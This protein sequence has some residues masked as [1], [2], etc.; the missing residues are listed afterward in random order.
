[1]AIYVPP[2]GDKVAFPFASGTPYVI[3]GG[4]DVAFRFGGT[5]GSLFAVGLDSSIFG[6]AVL[7]NAT[8]E[9]FPSGWASGLV[10]GNLVFTKSLLV[11]GIPPGEFGQALLYNLSQE[12][13]LGAID[14]FASGIPWVSLG[15][16]RLTGLTIADAS[17][18]GTATMSGGV[19][20]VDM[21]GLGV[22]P[23]VPPSPVVWFQVREIFPA[24]FVATLWGLPLMDFQH[25]VFLGGFG[26]EVFGQAEFFRPRFI[27]DMQ[28]LGIRGTVWGDTTLRLAKQFVAPPGWIG[29]GPTSA[30]QFGRT[31]IYNLK[32]IIEQQFDVTPGDGGVFGDFNLVMNRNQTPRPDGLAAGRY[33]TP[34]LR[35]AARIV[36]TPSFID[37]TLWGDNLVAPAIRAI[38]FVGTETTIWG[39]NVGT[40]V[41]NG[42]RVLAPS[43]IDSGTMGKPSRVWSNLQTLR[44]VGADQSA[45]G[46]QMVDFAIRTVSPFS[47]PGPPP[48]GNVD[49]ENWIRFVRVP[50]FAAGGAGVPT[51]E[52]HFTI[53]APRS[54]LPPANAF[55]EGRVRNVTPELPIFGWTATMFGASAIH[56]QFE[57]YAFQSFGGETFG[58]HVVKDRRITV[59][60]NGVGPLPISQLHQVRNVTPDPPSQQIVAPTGTN[61]SAMGVPGVQINVLYASGQDALVF[62]TP[63]FVNNGILVKGIT[64]PYNDVTGVQCGIPTFNGTRFVFPAGI[65]APANDPLA[66]VGPR[67]IWA[68]QGYPYTTGYWQEQGQQMDQAMFG[69][70][71]PE[72]PVFGSA[73]VTHRDREVRLTGS[74]H[75]SF[76][77]PG[78]V[79]RPL[80]IRA[81]GSTFQ[82]LGFPTLNGGG[83]VGLYGFD[84]SV[85][86]SYAVNHAEDLGPRTIRPIGFD[87][88]TMPRQDV[89]LFNRQLLVT[90]FN[91]FQISPPAAPAWPRTSS[92]IS[93]AYAPFPFI[94][95]DQSNFGTPWVSN[96]IRYLDPAG[97]QSEAVAADSPGSFRDR[98]RVTKQLRIT[99]VSVGS[100][101]VMGAPWASLGRH[102]IAPAS[103]EPPGMG[104]V[105][106]APVSR[107]NPDGFEDGVFGDLQRWEAGKVKPYGDDLAA[108]GRA[109][110]GSVVRPTGMA[111]AVGSPRMGMPVGPAGIDEG[112][113]GAPTL[114]ASWC[115]NRAIA[116]HEGAAGVF[117]QPKLEVS[118]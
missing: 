108:Y 104:R 33:G 66:D 58:R 11:R 52:Q 55:G 118:T 117:G 98:M 9:I 86:G 90:G 25:D 72:R 85:F 75:G 56:N 44:I 36:A 83:D 46:L 17:Q 1:M 53:I 79:Q 96:F 4:G 23:P 12:V 19:R 13:R 92:W 69:D 57:H 70:E 78:L 60:P 28:D 30:E 76:G 111:G 41:Y 110:I 64:P 37:F 43:G 101:S 102:G 21:A 22:D 18:F 24:W 20:I 5:P 54:A 2:T 95:I 71:H 109:V 26:G 7:R 81:Q 73:V 8:A 100:T 31:Q 48:L 6:A 68:P 114:V 47:L 59:V 82:K 88:A 99:D 97:W 42:A 38:A 93:N 49:V 107:I 32:Q 3:P 103:M 115:G 39:S 51:V 62:G 29:G 40:I 91:A 45:F 50:G 34:D 112:E 16:R 14:A 105:A 106:V 35:N 65:E 61:T 87:A 113:I 67:Y 27:V 89:Q 15:T 74:S 84:M 10:S 63:Q 77:A 80:Y 94:G 116:V